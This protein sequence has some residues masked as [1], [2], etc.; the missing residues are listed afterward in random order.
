[1]SDSNEDEA[2]LLA[3]RVLV[4]SPELKELFA[5]AHVAAFSERACFSC[6]PDG[7]VWVSR[8]RAI[9]EDHLII[10]GSVFFRLG[11]DPPHVVRACCRS[12][13]P[14]ATSAQRPS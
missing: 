14:P 10:L 12:G 13:L 11:L 4:K 3:V 6:N 2:S 8:A 9:G 1:M 5:L 7:E